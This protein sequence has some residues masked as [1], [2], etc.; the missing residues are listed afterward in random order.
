[1]PSSRQA[2]GVGSSPSADMMSTFALGQMRVRWSG[3]GAMQIAGPL[4]T[5]PP[6]D[7]ATAIGV[8]RAAVAAGVDHIDTAQLRERIEDN[9]RTLRVGQLA[10]M[11]LRLPGDGRHDARF[12]DQL[13]VCRAE[14]VPPRRLP[15]GPLL[16]ECLSRGIAFETKGEGHLSF[17]DLANGRAD[18]DGVGRGRHMAPGSA[19]VPTMGSQH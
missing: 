2:R 16:E 17:Q 5:G 19:G 8:L 9:L 11:N 10:A 13:A 6:L 1:M 3:Y 12:D 15:C 4:A 7:R 18:N 14:P